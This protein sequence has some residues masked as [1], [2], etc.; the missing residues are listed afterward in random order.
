MLFLL[1][2]NELG[3]TGKSTDSDVND[4][5]ITGTLDFMVPARHRN[6]WIIH[7]RDSF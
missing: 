5:F 7:L 6:I 1:F 4:E 3:E 2:L